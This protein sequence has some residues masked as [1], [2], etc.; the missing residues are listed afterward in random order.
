MFETMLVPCAT[1]SSKLTPPT[2]TTVLATTA[3]RFHKSVATYYV[4]RLCAA[5]ALSDA[6]SPCS[7][8][9]RAIVKQADLLGT[10][11]R[12]QSSFASTFV[13]ATSRAELPCTMRAAKSSCNNAVAAA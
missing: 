4:A 12:A 10:M 11:L 3:T 5:T 13:A 1:A 6:Q 7:S 2:G 9:S 8:G